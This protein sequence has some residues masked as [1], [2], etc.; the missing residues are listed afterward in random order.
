MIIYPRTTFS[1][2]LNTY[3]GSPFLPSLL[4]ALLSTTI[5]LTLELFNHDISSWMLHPYPFQ[6]FAAVVGFGLVFRAQ[7]AYARY[8]EGRTS[9]ASMGFKWTDAMI[10]VRSFSSQLP[11]HSQ[12]A[13]WLDDELQHLLSL[14]HAVTLQTL[15]GDNDSTNLV[16]DKL[17]TT[18]PP[19]DITAPLSRRKKL[20]HMFLSA[21]SV[22][23]S[24]IT[25][26]FALNKIPVVGGVRSSEKASL[27][28]DTTGNVRVARIMEAITRLITEGTR[29]G[30]I[31]APGPIVSRVFQVL[32]EGH[33]RGVAMSRKIAETPFPLPFAQVIEFLV[34]IFVFTLPFI[35]SCWL[36]TQIAVTVATFLTSWCY[37]ALNEVAR[38]LEEPL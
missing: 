30:V 20:F 2:L 13:D 9:L 18:P 34:I 10:Q 38:M 25:S 31:D 6:L 12:H 26:I 5:A 33:E 27:F 7:L 1:L 19:V 23:S 28:A 21:N 11:E 8:W 24:Y 32:S 3:N 16:D 15:R 29:R 35:L 36:S 17:M 37:L 4:L 22:T 14:M